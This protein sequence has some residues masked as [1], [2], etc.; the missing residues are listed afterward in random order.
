M[1][2]KK[3]LEGLNND[4]DAKLL[5]RAK[6]IGFS[7]YQ[8]SKMIK[9]TEI[10]VRDLREDSGIKPVVKQ[11]D[12]VAAEYPCFT[13]YL[14]L[15]YNG[16]YSD[17]DFDEKTV[18]VLGSG[19]YRIGSSV[20]FD[21]C[22]VNCVRELRDMGYKTVMINY[23]P[24][25]VSTDYDEV[26]RLYF[27]E[28]TFESVMD[29]Y[30]FENCIGVILSMGGQIANNIA[31]SLHRKNVRII[32][33]NPENI[34]N[35]ENRFKFSRML[36][37]IGIDQPEWR[38]LTDT[39][40][41]KN[42]C[43]EV[44]YPCLIRPSYVLSGAMMSVIYSQQE[45]DE[46]LRN[47]I[48]S[49]DYPVVM[50]KFITGAKEIE[51]DAVAD[52]GVLKLWAISEHVEDAGVHS[53]DATLILPPKNINETTRNLLLRN[54]QKIA[55]KLEIDGPFNIQYIAKNN[56]LKVIECNL[57]VSRSFPFV[58]KVKDINFIRT[59]T[60][61][62]I[63]AD[64]TIDNENEKYTGVK[65]PQF[66]F[67]RL[68][69]ADN[70]LG[71]EMLSTGEVACF[72]ENYREA[73]LKAL[74]ATGFKVKNGCRVLISVGSEENKEEMIDSIRLLSESD[75]ELYGTEGTTKYYS[76]RGINI[77][78]LYDDEILDNIKKGFFGLVIN[79]SIPNK[80]RTTG[81][82][83]NGYFIRRL[84]IDYGIDIIINIK[85][86]KLYIDS[87]VSF[88]DNSKMIG[89]CDLSNY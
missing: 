72:G 13:N 15:T 37:Q 2:C 19:V 69:N 5:H 56:E 76:K 9:K 82:K 85:C 26:D 81:E 40:S 41:T 44:G 53:G 30:G 12:T 28:I 50:S 48:V 89:D 49:N 71:V 87:I 45:M 65:V 63:G 6:R 17:I 88:Y 64:Y 58:S 24:E 20:E 38:E 70:R 83:T 61:I 86:A 4:I 52:K 79:I 23:N 57:R 75:F 32:G 42:F 36:D 14:Y 43:N 46:Y 29:I 21:W 54:T 25:T 66:S 8:I 80:I 84:S 62:M 18:I 67:N 73:Y 33:T 27:D 60:R 31:M 10:Y 16:D 35:A 7:D 22:A 74:T 55:K 77:V 39:L 51:V 59:A 68:A 3:T 34:D 1:K 47:V 78:S 11:L